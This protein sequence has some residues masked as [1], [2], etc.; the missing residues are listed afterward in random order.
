[1]K[2]FSTLKNT[3]FTAITGILKYIKFQN[4]KKILSLFHFFGVVLDLIGDLDHFVW[5]AVQLM[6]DD[7]L[8]VLK[9]RIVQFSAFFKS[10]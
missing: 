6:R 4:N 5:S 2:L 3:P 7:L 8:K 1:M 9:N 10:V